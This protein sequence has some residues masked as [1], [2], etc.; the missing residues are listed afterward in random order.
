MRTSLDKGLYV[1]TAASL[2]F[3]VSEVLV[4]LVRTHGPAIDSSLRTTTLTENLVRIVVAIVGL[5]VVLTGLGLQITPILTALGVG[6]LAIAL[7]LQDTLS[8]LFAGLTV[9]RHIRIGNYI[10]LSSGE[11]GYLVDIDWRVSR[12]RQLTNNTVLVPNAKFSQSIVTNYHSPEHELVVPFEASV[13]YRSDLDRVEAI[14]VE[15]ARDVMRTVQGGVPSFEPVVRFHTFGDPGIGFSV[16][17]RA[18]EYVDQFLI[19]HEFVKRLHKRFAA[20]DIAI[21]LKSIA[22]R[23]DATP[24]R[25]KAFY[26]GWV[27][28]LV[29]AAAMVGTL[30]GRTQG[31]GLITEPLLSDLGIGRVDYAQLNLWATLIGSAGAIGIGRFID[32][33]GSRV[34]LAAVAAALGVTVVLMSR[35]TTFTGL[36]VAITLTRALGQSALSVVSIAMVGQWFVRRIDMAMAIYSVVLSVGFMIAFPVVGSLVQ[37]SGWRTAW[38]AVGAAILAGLV[39]L[40]LLFVRRNPES[41][42]IAADGDGAA[43]AARSKFQ[44]PCSGSNA[45]PGTQN[46]EPELEP[47]PPGSHAREALRTPAFWVFAVGAA[48]YGLVASG[49]GLFNESVLAERGF[50]PNVYYQTLVVTAITG[51]AGNFIGG[52]LARFVPLNRLMAVSLSVLAAGLLALPHISTLAMAMAWAV[53]MGLGGG[54]VMVLFFSVWPRL[55]G[56]RQLGRIQGVAQ[57]MTVLASAVGPLLLARVRGDDG[58]LQRDV[59]H[60]CGDGGRLRK[61]Q[62]QSACRHGW[63]EGQHYVGVMR[64]CVRSQRSSC[65]SADLPAFARLRRVSPELVGLGRR[66]RTGRP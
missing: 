61:P 17:L 52:W 29:A 53:M 14:T 11:E 15:V 55:Y 50:G 32:R 40:G 64:S 46:V 28:L 35:V 38:F 12:L 59:L 58:Q 62:Q 36:A 65:R 25:M 26:Y 37:S 4:R 20:E 18:Q 44:V 23:H 13:D 1:V 22:Q 6:G 21:P 27:V 41:I 2:T 5:L 54:L 43:A 56:R 16:I 3:L 31:L 57:A 10:K 48:L 60:S 19:K 9:A 8:N 7:A 63:P 42:G 24:P 66:R 39:P 45:E 49:I 47:E 30:P 34:V 33:F 51:L